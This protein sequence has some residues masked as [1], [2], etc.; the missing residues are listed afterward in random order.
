MIKLPKELTTVTPLSKILAAVLLISL[1][2]IGFFLGI[3][4]QEMIDLTE[5]QQE[6]NN[7]SIPRIPTPTPIP[8]PTIDPSTANWKTYRNEEFGFEVG[9]PESWTTL[10]RSSQSVEF[11]HPDNSPYIS[12]VVFENIGGRGDESVGG[13]TFCEA[14][15]GQCTTQ[16]LNI[17]GVQTAIE[18][19]L[20]DASV[21]F[22]IPGKNYVIS[23]AFNSNFEKTSSE[24]MK[25]F[26]QILSTFR[27]TQ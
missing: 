20:H 24:E 15:P 16:K 5:R 8:M 7:L 18:W 26:L 3:R 27:F 12:L 10:E 2:F 9:Y 25:L 1:P 23:I 11:Q 19:R 14:Y 4:Y 17:D 21:N 13:I 6:E 22:G